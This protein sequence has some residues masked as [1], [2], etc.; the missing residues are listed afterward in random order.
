MFVEK[1]MTKYTAMKQFKFSFNDIQSNSR[2]KSSFRKRIYKSIT[3]APCND[4]F[5]IKPT[6]R[7]VLIVP[8]GQCLLRGLL[9]KRMSENRLVINFIL[10]F[11]CA[12]VSM[13]LIWNVFVKGPQGPRGDKGE[14]GERGS[15]GIKGHRGFPGNPGAP[16]SPVSAPVL[17]KN[18]LQYILTDETGKS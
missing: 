16:G 11:H 5:K 9:A 3:G 4:Q 10:F 15:N 13:T 18:F 6:T 7:A 12:C 2:S 17:L 14:T 1:G 8:C